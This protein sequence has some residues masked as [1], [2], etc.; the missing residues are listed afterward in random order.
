MENKTY[1]CECGKTFTNPQS[2]NG[3]KSSCKVHHIT[4]YGN[5]NVLENRITRT[6]RKSSE[7]NRKNAENAKQEK[8]LRWIS[9][10][11][12]C[13]KC[14]KVMTEKFGSG[15]FCSRSCANSKEQTEEMNEKRRNLV[16]GSKAYSNENK[17]IFVKNGESVPDG[18]FQGNFS[19]SR[20]FDSFDDFI[21]RLEI[22][23]LQTIEKK[24]CNKKKSK[25]EQAEILESVSESIKKHN[26]SII[27][28][29]EL[30]LSNLSIGKTFSVKEDCIYAQY[31][32]VYM[33][34]HIK[35]VGYCVFVHNLLA[36][37]LLGRK[38]LKEEV[39]H[40]KDENK[41]HNT[42][43]NIYI[44]DSLASHSRFHHSK[45]YWLEIKSDVLVCNKIT[46]DLMPVIM[47][48]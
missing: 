4:K 37:E 13:E 43:D 6:V 21:K 45:L 25:S 3:H 29:Y 14:G 46:E 38:L 12:T 41:L 22:K 18:F 44:F 36:E 31:K 17:T 26:D 9:E 34:D 11:H 48:Q 23:H 5:L 20:N 27:R 32:A 42:F 47:N 16:L 33:T 10:Q 30:L 40:H 1:Q 24:R 8:L 35:S 15:R 2:F 19:L 7:T 39:V 28:E